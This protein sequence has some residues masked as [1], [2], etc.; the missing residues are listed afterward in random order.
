MPEYFRVWETGE[1][2][3]YVLLFHCLHRQNYY[4][5]QHDNWFFTTNK[6]LWLAESRESIDVTLLKSAAAAYT[7]R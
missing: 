6:I 3:S 5:C 2:R 1:S 7:H 4:F